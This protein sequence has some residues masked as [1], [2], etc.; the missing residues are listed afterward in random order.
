MNTTREEPSQSSERPANESIKRGLQKIKQAQIE[1]MRELRKE[2]PEYSKNLSLTYSKETNYDPK[3][4]FR[5]DED[6]FQ[7]KNKLLKV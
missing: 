2:D 7:L 1:V 6:V 5:T 3:P 4:A